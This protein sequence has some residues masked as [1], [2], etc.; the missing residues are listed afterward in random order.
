MARLI[1]ISASKARTD[2]FDILT[3]VYMKN[4]GY[5]IK[6]SGIPVAKIVKIEKPMNKKTKV[7]LMSF[8]GAWKNIDAE[9]VKKYIYEGRKDKGKFKRKLPNLG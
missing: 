3:A 4:K 7:D 6:K 5:L 1:T 9:K 8:A 2:F